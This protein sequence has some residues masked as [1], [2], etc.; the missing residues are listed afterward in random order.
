MGN[1]VP[2]DLGQLIF[3]LT[4]KSI[5][6]IG[7]GNYL[8]LY[9]RRLIQCLL[10]AIHVNIYFCEKMKKVGRMISHA[11]ITGMMKK[12]HKDTPSP[13]IDEVE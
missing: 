13:T 3:K 8:V 4:I 2:I 12:L 6:R 11:S 10:L 9:Y 1:R 5:K 7:K